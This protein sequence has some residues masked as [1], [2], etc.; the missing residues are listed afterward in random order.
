MEDLL[1]LV[2]RDSLRSSFGLPPENPLA[3]PFK[4]PEKGASFITLH[5]RD[6]L[7]GCSGTIFPARSLLEDVKSNTCGAAF[8]DPRFPRVT[9]EELEELRIELSLVSPVERL[10]PSSEEN[11]LTLLRP[12]VDGLAIVSENLQ[13]TFLPST[14]TLFPAPKDFF[15]ALKEKM[16][17]ALPQP[18]EE[19][20]FFRYTV[21]SRKE[22]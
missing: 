16:G 19:I 9:V 20:Q 17:I 21:T 14:W 3:S 2:A 15:K 4:S 7:R 12:G 6:R 18:F 5:K 8:T 1:L 22:Q 13:G 10:F 11:L